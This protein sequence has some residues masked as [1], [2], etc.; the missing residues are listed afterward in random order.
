M[1]RRAFTRGVTAAATAFVL[2]AGL[3]PAALLAAAPAAHA[4]GSPQPETV[5]PA[6]ARWFPRQET[7]TTAG[8]GGYVAGDESGAYRWVNAADGSQ[9]PAPYTGRA[10]EW[11]RGVRAH[12]AT[13]TVALI[14]ASTGA[15][16]AQFTLPAGQKWA[17]VFT[18][19]AI[20]T[21]QP[22]TGGA[23]AALH[24]LTLSGGQLTDR[25]VSG[26]PA[27][28][29]GVPGLTGLGAM[30]GDLAAVLLAAGGSTHTYLLDFGSATLREVFATVPPAERRTVIIGGD[31]LVAYQPN[32]TTAYS[33]PLSDPT[34][35]A[36]A[37]PVPETVGH[38]DVA[39]PVPV[40]VGDRI[41]FV[42]TPIA[43]H[44]YPAL[45]SV[46]AGG[47][48]AVTVLA[49]SGSSYAI[50]PD[51][52]VLVTGGT[53]P[54]DWA[55]RRIAA[56]GTVSVD[57]PLPPVPAHVY[58][59]SYSAG[60]LVYSTDTA[61]Q[62]PLLRRD[63]TPGAD[64]VAGPATILRRSGATPRPCATGVT[65]VPLRGLGTGTVAYTEP[66][67]DF[68]TAP[69]P[70][71][72]SGIYD[73]EVGASDSEITSAAGYYAVVDTPST[74]RQTVI[75]FRQGYDGNIVTT[76]PI[77][78]SAVWA[79]TLW[80]PGTAAGSLRPYSLATRTYG[81]AVQTAAPCTAPDDLQ[82][83]GRWLYWSCGTTAGVYDRDSKRNI[84]VPAGPATLGDGYLVR[85]D[86]AG[87]TLQL[88]DVHS[89][90]AVTSTLAA[91]PASGIADDRGITWSVDAFGGG[92]AYVDA[93]QRI[94]VLPLAGIPR[95]PLAVV[96]AAPDTALNYPGPWHGEWDFSRPTGSWTL[97]VRNS[98]GHEVFTTTGT[99]RMAGTVRAE[100]NLTDAD[101][102]TASDGLYTAT[103]VASPAA[104]TA[105]L[106]TYRST[107]HVYQAPAWTRDFDDDGIGDLLAMTPGGRLD[108]RPGSGTGAGTIGRTTRQGGGWPASSTYVPIGDLAGDP[109]NDLLVRDSAGDLYR[110][111]GCGALSYG[112]AQGLIGG[113]WNIYDL[114]TSPGDLTGDGR[115]DLLARTRSGDLYVYAGTASGAFAR[116]VR[117]GWGF[118]AYAALAGAQDLTGDGAGDL[119]ARDR[120][121]VLWRYDGDGHG[122][123]RPR[124]R[125]GGGWNVYTALAGV[126][127]ING[128][129]RCDLVARDTAGVL[130][131]YDG[132]G[133]G[134][135]APRGRIGGGWQM[136]TRLL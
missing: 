63:I 99:D 51:G 22:G 76:R 8:S 130:W 129:G 64:P 102:R 89:D 13:G 94:H 136:Y 123:L 42:R 96:A 48:P 82:A 91:I 16:T 25:T 134:Q 58:G 14:D 62:L 34:G 109:C 106:A 127:D 41:L 60:R 35:A 86:T 12:S 43:E 107:F 98:A 28:A 6:G 101:G 118:Q 32:G 18:P 7:L 125:V 131:R 61:E 49:Q 47:G 83:D 70:T 114:M 33:V 45:Q 26:L 29:T 31:Q 73:A 117:I 17:G 111:D 27:G 81:A 71:S 90:S 110:Y 21:T 40:P 5:V 120:S 23:L 68:V 100:W 126:G 119:L 103:L 37:T 93:D 50:A 36:T 19:D 10:T 59:L 133:D 67:S 38:G 121:G 57:R 4:D 75:D 85:H 44:A 88:T 53:G 135:F 65:C 112:P 39:N 24:V 20:L 80:T 9:V 79:G 2:G 3:L 97:S 30:N 74:A 108:V 92:V 84:A 56:D 128:D 69:V 105:P 104:A 1:L 87:G 54:E 122:G 116:R 15:T 46:P 113:G 77:T 78:A 66:G 55:V 95:S 132:L 52:S 72:V 11:N 124:V 115:P